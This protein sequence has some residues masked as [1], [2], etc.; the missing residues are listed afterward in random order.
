MI[1][2]KN[3]AEPTCHLSLAGSLVYFFQLRAPASKHGAVSR[4]L[5]SL[6]LSPMAA[7]PE[8]VT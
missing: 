4:W 1:L 5:L 8:A 2:N 6:E 3:Q 7:V